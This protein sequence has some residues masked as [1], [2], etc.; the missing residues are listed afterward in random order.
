MKM[1]SKFSRAVW[2][3]ANSLQNWSQKCRG[4]AGLPA[5]MQMCVADVRAA[6]SQWEQR[7]EVFSPAAPV[8]LSQQN[9]EWKIWDHH[10]EPHTH[11]TSFQGWI[12]SMYFTPLC[13]LA[14]PSGRIF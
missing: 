4:W 10:T 5:D 13:S 8:A 2:K 12:L 9:I 6:V 11:K 14:V 1:A 3:S 7:L